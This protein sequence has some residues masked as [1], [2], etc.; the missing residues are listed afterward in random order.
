[1]AE[2]NGA[3]EMVSGCNEVQRW[4]ALRKSIRDVHKRKKIKNRESSRAVGLTFYEVF[5]KAKSI[6][7]NPAVIVTAATGYGRHGLRPLPR[8]IRSQPESGEARDG[9]HVRNTHSA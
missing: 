4:R 7:K 8:I 6:H 5:C 1:M 9:S 2:H 3:T